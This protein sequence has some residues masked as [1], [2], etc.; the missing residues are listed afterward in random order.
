MLLYQRKLRASVRGRVW[1]LVNGALI[2]IEVIDVSCISA[3]FKR[4]KSR[5]AIQGAIFTELFI[6][7]VLHDYILE[8]G[9]E[10]FFRRSF[11]DV[12][13]IDLWLLR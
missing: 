7:L 13:M 6:R 3:V 5:T 9:L 1:L 4:V 11:K 12:N 10:N 2:S 8:V